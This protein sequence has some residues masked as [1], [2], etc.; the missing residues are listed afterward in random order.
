VA[1][2]DVQAPG[3]LRGKVIAKGPGTAVAGVRIFVE[4][5]DGEVVSDAQGRFELPVAVGSHTVW[6][7]HDD[8]PTLMLEN[9][10]VRAGVPA[11]IEIELVPG[12]TSNDD[13][14][15]R[16]KFVA[17]G[18]ASI[19][20]ERREAST[21][22]DA[23]GSEE[24]QKSPD[25][26]ASSATRRIV[27]A[28]IVGGQYLFARGLGGRYTNVRLNGVPLP[29]TDPDLPGF[30]LDLFPA[31]LLSSLTITKTFSPDIPGDFAG[32]SLN[33]V[34]R[35]FPDAFKLTLSAS[36]QYNTET[37]G[38]R[39]PS[40]EGGDTDFLGFD[41]GTR[42]L[43]DGVPPERIWAGGGLTLDELIAASRAFPNRWRVEERKALPNM[44]LGVSLGD[45]LEGSAGRFGYLLTIGYRHRYDGYSET[46]NRVGLD[47]SVE[48][49]LPIVSQSLEREVGGR[50][51]Q[52]G[53]LAS[54]S[55]EPTPQ[56]RLTGVGM[57]TQHGEDRASIW[58]GRSESE[59]T[60]IQRTE[61][62]F[63]ERQLI[64]NQLLGEH[65][66]LG[67]FLTIDWQLNTARTLR[68][69]PD[70]RGVTYTEGPLGYAFAPVA[71]SG[72][73]LYTNLE[74]VDYGGGVDLR[75]A[76]DQQR[77]IK[78]GYLGRSGDRDFWARRMGVTMDASPTERL[79]PPE[80][81]FVP[82][83]AGEWWRI[84]EVT[85][86]AD[87]YSAQED[88]HAGYL[89]F[90]GSIAG[91]VKLMGGARAE[92]FHQAIEIASP[93][94]SSSET[95]PAGSDRTDVDILPAAALI[96]SP[97]P[98][99]NVRAAYGGTVARPLVR[100]LAP[101]L[102]QDFVPRPT[103]QGNPDL[104]RTFIHNLDLRWE[105]FPTPTEVF[106]VSGFYKIFEDPIESVLLNQ[107][108]DITFEN[109]EGAT[110]YGAELEARLGLD[111]FTPSLRG[112]SVLGNLAL[113][114]SSVTLTEE[115]QGSATRQERPLAGQSPYV[116]NLSLG[117]DS[118]G[119]VF[120]AYLYYNVFGR[121]IQDVGRLGLPDVYEEA[122]HA[123]D[124]TAFWKATSQLTLGVSASNLLLQPVRVTQGGLDFT[125]SERGANFGL[126]LS[127]TP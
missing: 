102:N 104:Q 87:G 41:D 35:A 11:E 116:A 20:E 55:Y 29:S 34:T 56:H 91:P 43:P 17:G 117:Y 40:Y 44:S 79:L 89:M 46:V 100:E 59:G 85:L 9:V 30:Q 94:A 96:V 21:V 26:S 68:D 125:R 27:G 63:I 109:I 73:R 36:V 115:Q 106:A 113:I 84:N 90:D 23:L 52:V 99:M 86:P 4:G 6:V 81:L 18:V 120:S 13:W 7:I 53:A 22:T 54:L 32:G 19:L 45:T 123:L 93:F 39:Q 105:L 65:E 38:R 47:T 69:Q 24:I 58:R 15:I 28:S 97:T 103:T 5:H 110:S 122:F 95:P 60:N 92:S 49:A 112:F 62:R 126:S 124:C 61:L 2:A 83:Q 67:G 74:Q 1:P 16:A 70:T 76:L 42:A 8:F 108:G 77:A 111:V 31:S 37:T 119:S 75:F 10:D 12:K 64:F 114:R 127:F 78:L 82:E 25:S 57:L 48:P 80:Q 88:L 98:T 107:N 118:E 66:D 101:F 33:V 50:E 3:V 71:G 72:E 121:R 14:V 51:A